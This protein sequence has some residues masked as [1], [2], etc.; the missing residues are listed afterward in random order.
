MYVLHTELDATV[1]H[2][3]MLS[4]DISVV[5]VLGFNEIF[6][7]S[8]DDDK[9]C[10]YVGKSVKKNFFFCFLLVFVLNCGNLPD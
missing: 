6:T 2:L 3:I 1:S 10:Y 8:A 7:C 9:Q 4:N 5:T